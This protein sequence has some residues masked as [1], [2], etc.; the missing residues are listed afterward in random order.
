MP[1]PAH[2]R[3]AIPG[4]FNED[5]SPVTYIV[6]EAFAEG[7]F[8]GITVDPRKISAVL[9]YYEPSHGRCPC[10]MDPF[11]TETSVL[12]E[13][14]TWGEQTTDTVCSQC[15]LDPHWKTR[16]VA[17]VLSRRLRPFEE[18]GS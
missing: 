8:A 9:D 12:V 16:E 5:G 3:E 4:R 2:H 15:A 10:C 7:R 17:N 13:H 11:V 14:T 6:V 1:L 18:L